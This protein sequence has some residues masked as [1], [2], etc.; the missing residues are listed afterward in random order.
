MYCTNCGKEME[1]GVKFCTNC[2]T[3]LQEAV[4]ES[5]A[6][7]DTTDQVIRNYEKIAA[8]VETKR[9]EYERLMSEA[10]ETDK[11]KLEIVKVHEEIENMLRNVQ[12]RRAGQE[13]C[14]PADHTAQEVQGR[15]NTIK[16]CPKCGSQIAGN[17]KFCSNCGK[18]MF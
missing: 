9:A 16:F 13:T 5:P 14:T 6:D 15:Q 17:A 7:E 2:G 12:V 1:D 11:I 10:V 8:E 18:Q 3:P 4:R